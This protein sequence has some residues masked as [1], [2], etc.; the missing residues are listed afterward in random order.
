MI[1]PLGTAQFDLPHLLCNQI[2]GA[3]RGL[4]SEDLVYALVLEVESM[5]RH[6]DLGD[7]Q[8][9]LS[10]YAMKQ[11]LKGTDIRLSGPEELTNGRGITPPYPAF[12]WF[13]HTRMC[14]TWPQGHQLEVLQLIAVLAELRRRARSTRYFR[15]TY[16]HVTD[17]MNCVWAWTKGHTHSTTMN[18]VLQK[19]MA[20]GV[21]TDIRP[22]FAWTLHKWIV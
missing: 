4:Q 6:M 8:K 18:L 14:H 19:I 3:A 1:P 22:I 7:E 11:L 9:H 13:W 17:C 5:V 21:A 15:Q 20:L 2:M 10:N 12:R 16:V